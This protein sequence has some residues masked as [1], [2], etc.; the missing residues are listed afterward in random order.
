[1]PKKLGPGERRM[2][3]V[4]S[5]YP[6]GFGLY[7]MFTRTLMSRTGQ[8]PIEGPLAVTIGAILVLFGMGAF[9]YA[10][11]GKNPSGD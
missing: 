5:L 7:V 8:V 10:W 2:L 9:M 4:L 6:F 11:K 3:M 1:M